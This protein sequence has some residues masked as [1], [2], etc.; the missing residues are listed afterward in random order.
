MTRPLNR[1]MRRGGQSAAA[2]AFVALLSP[3]PALPKR[4]VMPR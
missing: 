1:V 4:V 3:E 2:R